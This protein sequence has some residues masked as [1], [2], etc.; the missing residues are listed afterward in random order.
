MTCSQEA[1]GSQKTRA[2]RKRRARRLPFFSDEYVDLRYSGL[3][4]EFGYCW[5]L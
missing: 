3:V 5:F 4:L 1:R 2:A